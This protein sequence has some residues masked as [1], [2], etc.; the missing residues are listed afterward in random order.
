MH[1][2]APE[3]RP[4]VLAAIAVYTGPTGSVFEGAA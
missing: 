3:S 1:V 2:F 4:E